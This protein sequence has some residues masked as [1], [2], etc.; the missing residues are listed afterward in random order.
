M[1]T[2]T[3]LAVE[4]AERI[5]SASSQWEVKQVLSEID[6]LVY[7]A[8]RRPVSREYKVSLLEQIVEIL[9]A[10][11]VRKSFDN[12]EYLALVQYM[13]EQLRVR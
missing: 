4:F 11:I 13:L 6:R 8:D 2:Q 9:R 10:G 12:A 3:E 7:E 5:R 1:P